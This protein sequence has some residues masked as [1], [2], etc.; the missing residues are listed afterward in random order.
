VSSPYYASA[1]D[2]NN[3][4]RLDLLI[5]TNGADRVAYN[6][7][8]SGSG[9]VNWSATVPFQ[10]LSGSDDGFG[11]N[12]LVIDLDDD[13]WN[14]ALVADVD[15]DLSGCT[16][17]G[18]IYHNPGG[19][20]GDLIQLVEEAE[21]SGSSGWKGVAGITANDMRG[22]HDF[23]VFDIDNDG[24]KDMI[25]GT[26]TGTSVWMSTLNS[27]L[28]TSYCVAAANSN[29]PGASIYLQGS[30][31]VG[32]EDLTMNADGA[33]STQ[34]GVFFFGTN[35]V[36]NPFGDG[37]LC[38]NQNIERVWPPDF[39][40]GSGSV[41]RTIGW[42]AP[43]AGSLNAGSTVNFQFWFRDPGFGPAGFNLSDA[44]SLDLVP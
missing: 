6:T 5:S 34:P 20:P 22:T 33:S 16:R 26:C 17:R 12:N 11:S 7:G 38:T 10:F 18:H 28:G 15:I 1:G 44:I 43:Y 2:L 36:Q 24:D 40:D 14:D 35:Q 41:S 8:N 39:T 42:G 21:M 29:G 25:I 27:D 9:L 4:D 19:N 32:A 31:S 23:A 13:G 3:D 30:A 37:F